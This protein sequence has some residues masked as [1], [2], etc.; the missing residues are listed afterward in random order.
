MPFEKSRSASKRIAVIGG[1]ISGLG[2]AH[3][4]AD[5]HNVVLF[6]AEARLGGHARTKIAGKRGDQWVDTG[7]IVFN[8]ATYP[9]LTKLFDEL[10][11]PV[12]PSDMSFGV[13]IDG[14]VFEYA[15][16]NRFSVLAQKRNV[17]RPAFYGMIRDILKFNREAPALA[18]DPSLTIGQLL[19]RLQLGAWFRDY[20]ILPFSGAIWST[21]TQDI[22]EF[23]AEAMLRFFK[24]HGLLNPADNHDW[25]TVDGGSVQYV[26]RLEQA[27][28]RR[29]VHLRPGT[30][31]QAVRRSPVGVDIKTPGDDWESFDEVIFATHSDVTL[32]LLSDATGVER[33]ALAAVR[34]QPNEAILHADTSVM[35]KRKRAW[36]SWVYAEEAGQNPDRIGVSYWMNSLQPIPKDDPMFVTLN[37]T[38]P[39]RDELIYDTHTFMH[40][41]YDLAALAAQDT[42]RAI[43]GQNRTWF[44]GAWMRNGFHEDGIATAWNVAEAILA[45]E[46]AIA[47]AA[48]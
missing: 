27:L 2:A 36:A 40:P 32:R 14:G 48:Q 4:L 17:F 1:G 30:P 26:K 43:N 23:P 24:N 13:S 20:Y 28:F 7:F 38:R 46:D 35:P 6:E 33:T 3:Y 15:L 21:P 8:Y 41:V 45:E 5:R 12:A 47:L 44:C 31:V 25:F 39:I 18:R 11:V 34:Y 37:A 29:G 16:R 42:I 9:H 19:E 22:L 10:D